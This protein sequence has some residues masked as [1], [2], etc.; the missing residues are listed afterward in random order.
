MTGWP[1]PR[2][3]FLSSLLPSVAVLSVPLFIPTK[4]DSIKPGSLFSRALS[5][6]C[7]VS[8]FHYS[9]RFFPHQPQAPF[10]KGGVFRY[11]HKSWLWLLAHTGFSSG[12]GIP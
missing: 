1:L 3:P 8:R 9:F 2:S 12:G 6:C 11:G 4:P 10:L 5:V 7:R